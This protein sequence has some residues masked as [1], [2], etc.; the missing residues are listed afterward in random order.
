MTIHKSQGSEYKSV[1][2]V[3][4]DSHKASLNRNALFTGVTRAK[5]ECTLIYMQDAYETA[6]KTV[7]DAGRIT[8]LKEKIQALHHQYAMVYGIV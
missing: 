4:L 3:L 1:I 7:A 5:K 2:M 6:V 8:F